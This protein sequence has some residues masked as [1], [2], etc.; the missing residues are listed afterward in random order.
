[1][2]KE[3]ILFKVSDV[4]KFLMKKYGKRYKFVSLHGAKN[5]A[6]INFEIDGKVYYAKIT[7][8]EFDMFE[9]LEGN[10]LRKVSENGIKLDWLKHLIEINDETYLKFLEIYY[11]KRDL[12]IYKEYTDKI[13][14]YKS[15]LEDVVAEK[16]RLTAELKKISKAELILRTA[17][18]DKNKEMLEEITLNNDLVSYLNGCEDKKKKC[19]RYM[20]KLIKDIVGEVKETS[21]ENLQNKVSNTEAKRELD[22]TGEMDCSNVK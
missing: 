20:S 18:E 7:P 21:E 17:I 8:Y 19:A 15:A 2:N 13:D 12:E 9:I 3:K 14:E 10:R 4:D 6:S 5:K 22:T 1:M 16:I 11:S